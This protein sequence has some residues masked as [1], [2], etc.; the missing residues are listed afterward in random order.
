MGQEL[1]KNIWLRAGALLVGAIRFIADSKLAAEVVV[2]MLPAGIV[3]GGVTGVIG[4]DRNG[5]LSGL[6]ENVPGRAIDLFAFLLVL[7]IVF[8]ASIVWLLIRW[9]RDKR[10]LRR[11]RGAC[12][13][14]ESAT[15]TATRSDVKVDNMVVNSLH[16]VVSRSY[17]GHSNTKLKQLVSALRNASSEVRGNA[18]HLITTAQAALRQDAQAD[19]AVGVFVSKVRPGTYTLEL[20]ES[21][22]FS[23]GRWA[24]GEQPIV[25]YPGI[26]ELLA[27]RTDLHFGPN[28]GIGD[29]SQ[30]NTEHIENKF[31]H[32]LMASIPAYDDTGAMCN[33]PIGF[34]VIFGDSIKFGQDTA[35]VIVRQ[36]CCLL[37]KNLS[38]LD[39]I[40]RE[41]V[42]LGE[43]S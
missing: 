27:H 12:T 8:L 38:K 23:Q 33:E 5:W 41:L 10:Q 21:D 13:Y 43:K 20:F 35:K 14:D 34:I 25:N 2:P 31:L 24:R 19:C 29:K 3:V 37:A 32:C 15:I 42:A 17:G 1:P 16:D 6:L 9:S 18:A 4:A 7:C 26:I 36:L 11:M 30:H 39:T 28:P 22:A 40:R